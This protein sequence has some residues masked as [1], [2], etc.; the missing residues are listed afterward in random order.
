VTITPG[1]YPTFDP[2]GIN[3]Q[4]IVHH[5]KIMMSE[6]MHDT[7]LIT[8][9]NEPLDV[10]ELQPGIPVVMQYG[11]HPMDVEMFYG[12]I[13]HV[14]NHYDRAVTTGVTYE[15]VICM[16]VSYALKDPFVGAWTNIQASSVVKQV[17]KQ[18]FLSTLVEDDDDFWPSLASPGDSA[19]SFLSQLAAKVGYSL[20][21]NK[22]Q[23]RFTSADFG[24][25]QYWSG[26]QVFHTRNSAPAYSDQSITRFST[27]Q[28]EA[29]P[30]P[31]HQKA[32]RRLS[33]LDS[34]GQIIGAVDD[35]SSLPSQLGQSSTY[36]FFGQQ[37]SDQV[38]TSQAHAQTI[39]AGM[40]QANR[41]HYQAT[42]TLSG[43]TSVRQGMPIV[44]QGIDTSHDGMW[45]VQEV[46]HKILSEG[47][48]MDVCLGRDSLGDTGRLPT[49]AP[50][51]A[52]SPQNPFAYSIINAPATRLIN[53]RWRAASQSNFDVS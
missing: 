6:G 25:R 46:T 21:C 9:R 49:Q 37:I 44:L 43:R 15:D 29:L 8:L 10:P 41:F 5:V 14:E 12:Y 13:D 35:G 36:P 33:G 3:A 48:A 47:Y 7:A 17:A 2:G 18:Y 19:W 38:V 31:G 45:W 53:R 26:M 11:W 24:L 51:V 52:Y 32:I 50:G 22:S 20:A 4:K 34:S 23:I 16:G 27:V 1:A 42:A 30:I 28:G 39:L 40:T